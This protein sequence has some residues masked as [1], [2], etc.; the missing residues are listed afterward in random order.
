M[1]KHRPETNPDGITAEELI[2]EARQNAK[3]RHPAGRR[4]VASGLLAVGVL[5]AVP[6]TVAQ[7]APATTSDVAHSRLIHPDTDPARQ[8]LICPRGT[9]LVGASCLT[10]EPAYPSDTLGSYGVAGLALLGLLALL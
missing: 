5:A 8:P 10:R 1:S 2:E 4:F 9:E 3:R 7:A 6:A